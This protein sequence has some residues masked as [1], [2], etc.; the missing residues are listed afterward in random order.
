M[1]TGTLA[2][3]CKAFQDAQNQACTCVGKR[4]EL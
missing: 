3:G 2:L 4:E 1:Y